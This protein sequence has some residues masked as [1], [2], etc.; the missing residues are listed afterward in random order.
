MDQLSF[1]SKHT[2]IKGNVHIFDAHKQN[3]SMRS[4]DSNQIGEINVKRERERETFVVR[5]VK[6][7][8]IK[9]NCKASIRF[10]EN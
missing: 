5:E 4:L 8:G 9:S 6:N 10:F 7:G 1:G 2:L 3:Q